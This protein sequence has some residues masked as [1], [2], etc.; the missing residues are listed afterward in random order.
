MDYCPC[1]V[2]CSKRQACSTEILL[3]AI[4][5]STLNIF[6]RRSRKDFFF[7]CCSMTLTVTN[8]FQALLMDVC[9]ISTPRLKKVSTDPLLSS[10]IKAA[11]ALAVTLF[12]HS[13]ASCRKKWPTCLICWEAETVASL[14][15]H[16][17][18]WR[19][20][21]FQIHSVIWIFLI[22]LTP[23]IWTVCT[24]QNALSWFWQ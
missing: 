15:K 7:L 11:S 17:F 6:F 2:L 18:S 3:P 1:F 9:L 21:R 16:Y 5:I 13:Q 4:N 23:A 12:H 20:I 24:R 14:L 8:V 22:S 19:T 10:W